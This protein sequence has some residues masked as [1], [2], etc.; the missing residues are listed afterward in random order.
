MLTSVVAF[1]DAANF[2]GLRKPVLVN[3]SSG[4]AFLDS[5]VTNVSSVAWTAIVTSSSIA[6]SAVGV[7]NSGAKSLT[8]GV[9][10]ANSELPVGIVIPPVSI[11]I[12][13]PWNLAK[14]S[15]ISL[16]A[17]GASQTSGYIS[18]CFFQ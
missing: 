14:G 3:G 11:G 5:S 4:C 7:S 12:L 16:E 13:Y 6:F 2:L 1:A 10:A 18:L 17:L 8:V 15:R 9:G